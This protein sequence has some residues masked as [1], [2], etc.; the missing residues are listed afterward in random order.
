M[1]LDSAASHQKFID[2]ERLDF[3]LVVDDGSLAKV[4]GVP[5]RLGFASRQSILIG[6]D[7]KLLNIWRKVSPAGHAQQVLEAIKAS[8]SPD[9]P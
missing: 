8:D 1:S 6:K 9:S 5:V 4:F 7:G 2:K 3:P